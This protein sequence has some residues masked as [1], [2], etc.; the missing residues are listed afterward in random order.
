[1]DI[2]LNRF[3]LLPPKNI[4]IVYTNL[5]NDAS[6]TWD[7]VN[8]DEYKIGY[9]VY[10]GT[11]ANGIFYKLNKEVILTNRYEDKNVISNINTTY[12]YKVSTLYY[13][14]EQWVESELSNANIYRVDNTN[15]W[16]HKINERNMWILKNTGE[17][18]DLYKRKTEGDRC[19]CFDSV[20]GSAANPNCEKC[21]GTGFVGGYDA[22]NQIYIRQKPANNQMDRTL[23]GLKINNNTGA[24]TICDVQIRDRDILINPQGKM[25]RVYSTNINHAAGYYFHQEIQMYEV[26]TNDP[27]YKLKRKT[28]YPIF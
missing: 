3:K 16:F 12:W 11:I 8:N 2:I 6:V 15:K 14:G 18:F 10:R 27:I 13:N 17:L 28:L 23:E 9:N 22:I 4:K 24:W 20:R 26:E 1:L 7:K 19:T 5:K 25:F 21:Y